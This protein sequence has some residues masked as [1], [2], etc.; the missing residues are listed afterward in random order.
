M[1]IEDEEKK[2]RIWKKVSKQIQVE[3]YYDEIL[4][5][6]DAFREKY[7]YIGGGFTNYFRTRFEADVDVLE[8]IAKFL[9]WEDKFYLLP[10]TRAMEIY[11]FEPPELIKLIQQENLNSD[12]FIITG[13]RYHYA[14][15]KDKHRNLN[16]VGDFIRK[17]VKK[18]INLRFMD[19]RVMLTTWDDLKEE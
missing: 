15:I 4:L 9:T 3:T 6:T 5:T 2:A 8:V 10:I 7:G 13:D 14:L 16:G 18:Q 1:R 19:A 12:D 11:Q 17:R